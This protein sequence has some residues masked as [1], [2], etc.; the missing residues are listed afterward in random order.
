[1]TGFLPRMF[2]ALLHSVGRRCQ[3]C[4]SVLR[5]PRDFP[6]CPRCSALLAPRLGGYCPRCGMCYADPLAP[7]YP[8]LA[9]RTV[10]PPWSALAFHGLYAGT[11]KELV[12]RHK[13]S[14]DHGLGLIL[15]SLIRQAWEVH[16]L[17]RPDCIVP[18]PMLPGKV[19]RRGFNQSVEL[20]RMLGKV[21]GQP[22]HVRV[23]RKTRDTM[24]QSSLGRSGRH[25]NVVGAFAASPKLA[26]RHALLVDDVMTTG[27]TLTACT[28]ACL[29]AGAAQV[30]I[31]VLARAV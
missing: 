24:A 29:E 25:R 16:G 13:F 7:V 1:M 12:H 14:H 2:D 19:L 26:G 21:M 9:C 11:L 10:P 17:D 22:P 27:A 30:D 4:A 15:R 23:L 3:L 28:R 31:F 8:C 5:Q 18:V 20:S 6:L